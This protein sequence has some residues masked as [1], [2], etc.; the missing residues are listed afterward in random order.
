MVAVVRLRQSMRSRVF[1]DFEEAMYV[2][3]TRC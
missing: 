2:T 3:G 1:E